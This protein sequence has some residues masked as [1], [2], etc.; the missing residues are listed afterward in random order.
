MCFLVDCA[1]AQS[2]GIVP[3]KSELIPHLQCS[4]VASATPPTLDHVSTTVSISPA[5]AVLL[6]SNHEL[7]H[8][9]SSSTKTRQSRS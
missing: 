2:L 7:R 3:A 8:T 5:I 1:P 6:A 4:I 9:S